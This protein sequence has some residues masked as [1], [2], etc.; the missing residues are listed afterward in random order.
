MILMVLQRN[1]CAEITK[2]AH[3]QSYRLHGYSVLLD[4]F[5]FAF[6]LAPYFAMLV[7]QPIKRLSWAPSPS[8]C[9]SLELNF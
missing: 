1:F 6:A 8:F 4:P 5:D 3:V 2:T 7:L 9:I